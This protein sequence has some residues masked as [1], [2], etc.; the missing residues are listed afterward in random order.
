VLVTPVLCDHFPVSIEPREG[1]HIGVAAKACEKRVPRAES[2]VDTARIA[3]TLAAVWS[4]VIITSTLGLRTS[5]PRL[6]LFPLA[7]P[8]EGAA[9]RPADRPYAGSRRMNAPVACVQSIEPVSSA[10]TVAQNS[11]QYARSLR[12]AGGPPITT[13][14]EMHKVSADC[15]PGGCSYGDT[16]V[17]QDMGSNTLSIN[18]E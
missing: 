10:R 18:P 1:P 2:L 15:G 13:E 6:S 16:F 3:Q 14:G 11:R 12:K 4:S 8:S 9:S 5:A 7:L 17:G